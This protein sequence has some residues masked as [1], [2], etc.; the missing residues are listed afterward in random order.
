MSTPTKNRT[1]K[2]A[3]ESL[4]DLSSL[5]LKN[6]YKLSDKQMNDICLKAETLYFTV[7]E[8]YDGQLTGEQYFALSYVDRIKYTMKAEDLSYEDAKAEVDEEDEERAEFDEAQRQD[9]YGQF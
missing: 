5:I 9:N 2:W 6:Y 1:L 4:G 8:L 7:K 3:L